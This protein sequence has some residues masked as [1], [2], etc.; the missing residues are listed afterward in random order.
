MSKD[1]SINQVDK[2]GVRKEN[3]H[4]LKRKYGLDN[5]GEDLPKSEDKNKYFDRARDRRKLIGSSHSSEKTASSSVDTAISSDNKGGVFWEHCIK[6]NSASPK[7][8]NVF[9]ATLKNP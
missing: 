4:T 9:E 8:L 3:L 7:S 6:L 2:E 5:P 1:N